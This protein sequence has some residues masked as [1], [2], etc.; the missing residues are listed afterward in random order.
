VSLDIH[1]GLPPATTSCDTWDPG[2]R[3]FENNAKRAKPPAPGKGRH[4]VCYDGLTR[5]YNVVTGTENSKAGPAH[6]GLGQC[7]LSVFD[8][9]VRNLKAGE[10]HVLYLANGKK[11]PAPFNLSWKRAGHGRGG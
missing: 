2:P 4:E 1:T 5:G 6:G 9:G 11:G 10:E 3:L 8:L 7:S